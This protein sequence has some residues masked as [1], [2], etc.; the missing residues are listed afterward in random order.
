MSQRAALHALRHRHEIQPPIRE[1]YRSRLM[2]A[3][4]RVIATP[5]MTCLEPQGS[6]YL[7]VDVRATGLGSVAVADR[8][9]D[10][11]HVL[12]LP[13]VALGAGCDGYLRLAMTVSQE[14][15]DEAFDRIGRTALFGG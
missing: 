8:I 13:G 15:I 3:Y 9:F 7:W 2:R 1:L 12:T 14:R 10:E 5:G 11:T 6:I 4:E